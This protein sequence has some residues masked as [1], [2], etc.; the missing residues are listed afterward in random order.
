MTKD[1]VR[2]MEP[3]DFKQLEKGTK[4]IEPLNVITKNN[5][6]EFEVEGKEELVEVK[7]NK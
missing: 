7:I 6:K 1:D 3:V 4:L 2:N 5:N